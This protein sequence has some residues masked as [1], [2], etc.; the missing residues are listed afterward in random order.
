MGIYGIRASNL[1]GAEVNKSKDIDNMDINDA[2]PQI[3]KL[4]TLL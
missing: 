3:D 1:R 2:A 4:E